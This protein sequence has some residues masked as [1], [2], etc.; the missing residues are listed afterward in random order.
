[1]EINYQQYTIFEALKEFVI[2]L[3]EAYQDE[4]DEPI[5]IFLAFLNRFKISSDEYRLVIAEVKDFC[6]K[7]SSG[8]KHKNI[9][10]I[11]DKPI[12]FNEDAYIDVFKYITKNDENT[13]VIFEHLKTILYLV[14]GGVTDEEQFLDNFVKSFATTFTQPTAAQLNSESMES[15]EEISAI[16]KPTIE[17]SM[18][19]FQNK[20]LNVD[21]FMKSISFKV[22]EYIDN[23][24]IPGIRKED[25]NKI[26][27]MTIQYEISEL[28][29]K[30]FEI[31]SILSSSGLLAQMPIEKLLSVSNLN[32][33]KD[34]D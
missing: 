15:I 7:S 21:S 14:E 2:D 3:S 5:H 27:D 1:M 6:F 12:M 22:K 33:Q 9:E 24:D 31:F 4:I 26:L 8:I 25:L 32:I 30:K 18:K 19:E 20:K 23:K 29:D 11:S 13:N 10:E 16:I 34:D 28:V 17:Q